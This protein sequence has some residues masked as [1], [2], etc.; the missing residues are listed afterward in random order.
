MFLQGSLSFERRCQLVAVS[1]RGFYRSL[2]E[3][4]PTEEA[5][6]V[7]SVIQQIALE[8]RRRYGYRRITAELHRRGMQ[9]HHKRV[10][11]IMT[12]ESACDLENRRIYGQCAVQRRYQGMMPLLVEYGQWGRRRGAARGGFGGPSGMVCLPRWPFNLVAV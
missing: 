4:R 8:H 10:V 7:R 2:Q 3:Q 9:V 1:R 12:T 11:R 6:E 5:M